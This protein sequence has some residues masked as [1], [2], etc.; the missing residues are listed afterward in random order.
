MDAMGGRRK[1][2]IYNWALVMMLLCVGF[3]L[4]YMNSRL[5]PF[6]PKL[7]TPPLFC[8]LCSEVLMSFTPVVELC[9]N[10]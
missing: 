1:N 4:E 7:A 5:E 9:A 2:G 10:G 3:F 8:V 6:P